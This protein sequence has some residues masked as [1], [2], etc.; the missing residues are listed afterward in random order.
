MLVVKLALIRCLASSSRAIGASCARAA[1]TIRC[2]RWRCWWW[3]RWWRRRWRWRI[4]RAYVDHDDLNL[5][6]SGLDSTS[7]IVASV[8]VTVRN[9][10]DATRWRQRKRCGCRRRCR[11]RSRWRSWFDRPPC[12]ASIVARIP[13]VR[14]HIDGERK[15]GEGREQSCREAHVHSCN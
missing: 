2:R 9:V 1:V 15:D 11:R 14:R 12:R 8:Y 7:R 4:R 3:W 5:F 10:R 6:V 13:R